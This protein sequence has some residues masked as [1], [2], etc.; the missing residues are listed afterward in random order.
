[1]FLDVSLQFSQLQ[2]VLCFKARG[3]IA[4][5][6]LIEV[7]EVGFLALWTGTNYKLQK[8][9]IH[10]LFSSYIFKPSLD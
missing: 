8:E 9:V 3:L 5:W 1:M 2:V 10:K 4:L 7:S 6:N